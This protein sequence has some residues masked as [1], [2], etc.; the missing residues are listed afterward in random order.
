MQ[1]TTAWMAGAF[2]GR[3]ILKNGAQTMTKAL[4]LGG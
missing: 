3:A 4:D 1:S 2:S